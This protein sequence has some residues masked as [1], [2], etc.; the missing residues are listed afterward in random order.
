MKPYL[1]LEV[2]DEYDPNTPLL[3]SVIEIADHGGA[4]YIVFPAHW[5]EPRYEDKKTPT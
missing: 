3:G 4:F 5:I 1:G 2:I